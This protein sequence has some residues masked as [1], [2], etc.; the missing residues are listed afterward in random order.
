M[1]CLTFVQLYKFNL[2]KMLLLFKA[3]LTENKYI[4]PQQ[5]KSICYCHFK[6]K[7]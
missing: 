3:L 4:I 5:G 6:N 7:L 2:D 1:L